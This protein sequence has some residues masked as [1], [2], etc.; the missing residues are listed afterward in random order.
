MELH[1]LRYF[2]A[3]ARTGSFTKAALDEGVAQPSLSQQIARLEESVGAQLFDRLGR[4]VQLTEYGKS[5]LPQA[6]EILRQLRNAQISLESMRRTVS[7]RLAIGSIPTIMPYWLAPRLNDFAREYPDV[8]LRL[9]EDTTTK[10]VELLQ[11][12]KLDIALVA[13]PVSNPDMICSELFREPI[14]VVVGERHSL[15][16]HTVAHLRELRNERIILLKEGHCFRD[17]A[18]TVCHKAHFSP[19]SIFETDQFLSIFPLVE[20]GFGISLVPEMAV[21]YGSKGCRMLP[22][23]RETFRRIGYMRVRGHTAGAAQTAFVKWLR[24][25]SPARQMTS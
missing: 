19:E 7:G 23:D 21:H 16:S 9:V 22:L 11:A 2:C 18:L 1:Q 12:G 4:G 3:V 5:L 24:A 13:L 15:A 17:N 8:Q 25:I 6:T 10:L 14:R 20:A